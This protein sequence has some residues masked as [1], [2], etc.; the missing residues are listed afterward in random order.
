MSKLNK[1]RI[2]QQIVNDMF[3]N[4]EIKIKFVPCINGFQTFVSCS[5]L[6]NMTD[7]EFRKRYLMKD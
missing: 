3:K 2:G 1:L 4:I 7:K 5:E 6:F